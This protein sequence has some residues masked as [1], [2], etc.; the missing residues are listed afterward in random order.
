MA[1][2]FRDHT[3]PE[4]LEA[5]IIF[6][7]DKLDVIG[8]IG[9]VRTVAFDV[10]VGQPIYTEPSDR[11]LETGEKEPGEQHSSMHEYI[12][13]L[14]KIKDQLHTSLGRQIAAGRHRFMKSFF[15]RLG[16]EMQGKK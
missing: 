13:K 15:E 5:K 7:A 2:R 6:D 14:G 4:T 12:F 11:F 9:V 1:H 10:V 16:A 3:P 8:A